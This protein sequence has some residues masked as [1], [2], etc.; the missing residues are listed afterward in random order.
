M[1]DESKQILEAVSRYRTEI[2][3][4]L[5][6]FRV[7]LSALYSGVDAAA[8]TADSG[9]DAHDSRLLGL[10][11]VVEA[12]GGRLDEVRLFMGDVRGTLD[13]FGARIMALE[14]LVEVGGMALKTVEERLAAL[15]SVNEVL[16]RQMALE[17][18][19]RYVE[20]RRQRKL[21]SIQKG[22]G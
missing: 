3:K 13:L 14:K 17:A 7:E 9:L 16:F 11:A 4:L 15:D 8:K 21:E 20:E 6:G 2:D 22:N 1:K 12:Q 10:E 18:V 19:E 5:D